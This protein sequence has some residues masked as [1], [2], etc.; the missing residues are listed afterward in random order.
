MDSVHG[1]QVKDDGE[2]E[3]GQLQHGGAKYI[4]L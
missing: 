3:T 4:S 2:K 1:D